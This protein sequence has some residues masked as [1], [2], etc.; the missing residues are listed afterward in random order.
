MIKRPTVLQDLT[1]YKSDNSKP[2]A[3]FGLPEDVQF[4]SICVESNQ[5]PSTTVEYKHNKNSKKSAIQFNS[6]QVCSACEH[7]LE[8]DRIDWMLRE[9]KLIELCDRHRK[10]D[11]SYDCIVPG[12][13][14]KDS[15]YVSHE[16]KH[17]YGMHP[18]TITWSPHMYTDWGRK[19]FNN[20]FIPYKNKI[21]YE[22]IDNIPEMVEDFW[23]RTNPGL[24]TLQSNT[25]GV[26]A[27]IRYLGTNRWAEKKIEERLPIM[28][29]EFLEGSYDLRINKL[30]YEKYQMRFDVAMGEFPEHF[31]DLKPK[32]PGKA[33]L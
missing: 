31:I 20:R 27:D 21:F 18:L 6:D 4:C 17:K 33:A 11:G 3:K 28:N 13:G 29:K 2:H 25:R 9:Q 7:S 10:N 30:G 19:N 26:K 14:G 32:R 15:I 1:E 5:R 23:I 22:I 8:K 12:S 16:L 24:V